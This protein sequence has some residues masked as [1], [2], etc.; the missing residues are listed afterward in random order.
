MNFK[1]ITT[2]ATLTFLSGCSISPLT[3]DLDPGAENVI[4]KDVKPSNDYD[5][6]TSISASNGRGCRDFGYLGTQE[7][8]LKDL[9]NKTNDLRGDYA[10]IVK[11]TKPH[12][13]GGCYVNEYEIMAIIYRKGDPKPVQVAPPVQQ[14]QVVAPQ[15]DEEVFTKKMRELKALLDDG[16]LSQKEYDA[17]KAKLLDQGFNA[18]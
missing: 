1:I 10:Q 11:V 2:L 5:M 18:K 7:E 16:V 12:L 6:I 8:A 4:V 14:T 9:K 17:Q 3:V 15:S 13:D